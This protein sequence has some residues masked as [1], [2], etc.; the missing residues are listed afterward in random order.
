MIVYKITIDSRYIFVGSTTR[1]LETIMYETFNSAKNREKSLLHKMINEYGTDKVNSEVLENNIKSKEILNKCTIYWINK[2]N[3]LY[4]NNPYGLNVT[5]GGFKH[6]NID[7]VKAVK[8]DFCD[9]YSKNQLKSKYGINDRDI[10]A[11]LKKEIFAYVSVELNDLID[12]LLNNKKP[13]LINLDDNKY[14]IVLDVKNDFL[15][16]L[17]VHEIVKKRSL[18]RNFVSNILNFKTFNYVGEYLN[19]SITELKK[20]REKEIYELVK[21]IKLAYISGRKQSEIARYLKIEEHLVSSVL[22]LKRYSHIM[23]ELN[24]KIVSIKEVIEIEKTEHVHKSLLVYLLTVDG[25]DDGKFLYVGATMDFKA[26]IRSHLSNMKSD[27]YKN[28]ILYQKMNQYGVK[29][30][31]FTVLEKDIETIEK[32]DKREALYVDKLNTYFKNNPFGLNSTPTGRGGLQGD[33]NHK[34]QLSEDVVYEIK[35]NFAEG[36]MD[37]EE[38]KEIY[39]INGGMLSK[40]LTLRSWD[41]VAPEFNKAIND[42][43]ANDVIGE[44]TAY[45]IKK[46][47]VEKFSENEIEE[48][49]GIK[50]E[51][52]RHILGLRTYKKVGSEF[53]KK[54][55]YMNKEKKEN[56]NDLII[57]IKEDFIS[58]LSQSEIVKKR[59]VTAQYVSRILNFDRSKQIGEHLNNA[60]LERKNKDK[61]T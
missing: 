35:K 24:E 15:S 40:I 1:S 9:G 22:L 60:I 41:Y 33:F 51:V 50:K 12:E 39:D 58:G 7:L 48:K 13:K 17:S 45:M 27:R 34:A 59:G 61:N 21:S 38:I 29:K 5:H 2:L 56:R 18:D 32:L 8:T 36:V 42:I 55:I 25:G 3:S 23:E 37:R 52:F 54:I 14:R 49:T 53:N 6:I 31:K 10:K 19:Q 44:K 47:Y 28:H 30:I 46:M 11:I 57:S 4:V 16:G 26:R 20:E 43:L